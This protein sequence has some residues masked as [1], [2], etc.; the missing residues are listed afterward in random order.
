MSEYFGIYHPERLKGFYDEREIIDKTGHRPQ[1]VDF[2]FTL[3][4][5]LILFLILKNESI[6]INSRY[7]EISIT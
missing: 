5:F 4:L 7:M 2:N 3:N 1:H 6:L